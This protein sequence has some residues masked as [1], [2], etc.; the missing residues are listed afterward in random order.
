MHN[1][2]FRFAYSIGKEG[3]M[4]EKKRNLEFVVSLLAHGNIIVDYR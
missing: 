3:S 2:W 4:Q 1:E